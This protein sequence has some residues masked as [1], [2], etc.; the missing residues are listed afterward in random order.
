MLQVGDRAPDFSLPDQT[1]KLVKLSDFLGKQHVVLFFYPKDNT[2][3]CT[4]QSC[5]FRDNYSEFKKNGAQVL[6][7][8]ADS[9]DSHQSFASQYSLP[10]PLLSDDKG[11]ASKLF[12][13]G[14]WLGLLPNRVSFVIDQKGIIRHVFSSQLNATR[15]VDETL[16]SLKHLA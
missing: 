14:K 4:A 2:P 13:V 16:E 12:G 8:S 5:S 7:I 10:F 3:G 9:S 11:S 1:G 15:H 6:G